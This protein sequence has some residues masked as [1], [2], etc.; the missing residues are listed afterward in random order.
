MVIALVALT[1]SLWLMLRITRRP[2]PK[3]YFYFV[4]AIALQG[5]IGYV[6]YFN[7]LPEVI[8]ALHLLGSGLVW[9]AANFLFYSFEKEVVESA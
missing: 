9:T 4:S 2:V 3:A 7:G 8:V 1:I 6:Q 5:V